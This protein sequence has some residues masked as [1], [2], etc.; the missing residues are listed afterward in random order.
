MKLTFEWD[1]NKEKTNIKKHGVSFVDAKTA[2]HDEYAMQFYDPDHSDD[3]DRF[4]LLGTNH[5]LKTLVICHCF[6]QTETIIRIISARHA[7][8]SEQSA[9][10]SN[11]P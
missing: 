9:Y 4:I 10:W 6:R 7:D 5:Q 2:F 8:A 3:E 1:T 11:R